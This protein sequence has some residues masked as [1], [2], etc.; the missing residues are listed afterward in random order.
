MKKHT[1]LQVAKEYQRS[2]AKLQRERE[3]LYAKALRELKVH[4]TNLAFDW[5][6]NDQQGQGEFLGVIGK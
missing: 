2:I 4:D 3:R 1:R 6:F 5:F